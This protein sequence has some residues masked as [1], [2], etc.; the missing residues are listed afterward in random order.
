M[1]IRSYVFHLYPYICISLPLWPLAS[2]V[3]FQSVLLQMGL[4]LLSLEGISLC[5]GL[6]LYDSMGYISICLHYTCLTTSLRFHSRFLFQSVLIQMGLKLLSLEV[7]IEGIRLC[8]WLY[9]SMCYLSISIYA[10]LPLYTCL[11]PSLLR[12]ASLFFFSLCSC[13]WVWSSSP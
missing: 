6:W 8:I 3:L 9:Y 12:F 4:K 11:T 7:V 13:K 2:F 10:S 1:A 5:I